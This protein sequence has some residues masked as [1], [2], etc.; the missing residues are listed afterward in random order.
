MKYIRRLICRIFG[1][2]ESAVA[3]SREANAIVVYCPR[4]LLIQAGS[5]K[6]LRKT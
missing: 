2:P 1:H 5:L 3:V 4:C 6:S